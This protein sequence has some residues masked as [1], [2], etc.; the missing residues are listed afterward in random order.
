MLADVA[1]GKRAV[2]RVGKRVQADVSVGMAA[3][4]RRMRD[5]KA[6]QPDMIAG[7]E[8]VNIEALADPCLA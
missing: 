8:G 7:R 5:A 1:L 4:R 6:A 3:E 2:E